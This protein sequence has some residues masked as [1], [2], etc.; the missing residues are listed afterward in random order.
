[1]EFEWD[2]A[3]SRSNL[4]KHGIDFPTAAAVFVGPLL[5]VRS[6]FVDEERL[7]AIGEVNGRAVTVIYT[8]RDDRIRIIS[9][10]RARCDERRQYQALYP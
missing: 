2:E 7:L 4:A 6:A 9:A 5:T 3:K 10:R 1:M 8:L